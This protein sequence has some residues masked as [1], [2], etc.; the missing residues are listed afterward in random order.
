MIRQSSSLWWAPRHAY[1]HVVA[2]VFL[3]ALTPLLPAGL[4]ALAASVWLV[5]ATTHRLVARGLPDDALARWALTLLCSFLHIAAT[6]ELL[7]LF[8]V[9]N[10]PSWW[11]IVQAV[12]FALTRLVPP[13]PIQDSI[14]AEWSR[15]T[16]RLPPLARAVCTVFVVLAAVNL[17]IAALAGITEYDSI[18]T[19]VP[20][21]IDFVQQGHLNYPLHPRPGDTDAW[22]APVSFLFNWHKVYLYT[23]VISDSIVFLNIL[24]WL[25]TAGAFIATLGICHHL[26]VPR[27]IGL[28]STIIVFAAPQF[29]AQSANTMYDQVQAFTMACVVLAF[30][31]CLEKPSRSWAALFALA[32]V[33]V[34]AMKLS[35]AFMA[36]VLLVLDMVLAGWLLW[37]RQ[38]AAL[39]AG[40]VVG[41]LGLAVLVVPHFARNY[42]YYGRWMPS[43]RSVSSVVRKKSSRSVSRVMLLRTMKCLLPFSLY[44]VMPHPPSWLPFED[45]FHSKLQ[46]RKALWSHIS[47]PYTEAAAYFGIQPLALT[48]LMIVMTLSRRAW[49]S[50][51]RWLL[52][53]WLCCAVWLTFHAAYAFLFGYSPW[54]GRYLLICW[55]LAGPALAAAL[56]CLRPRPRRILI[57]IL[58]VWTSVEAT[59]FFVNREHMPFRDV[60]NI[61]RLDHFHRDPRYPRSNIPRARAFL[62]VRKAYDVKTDVPGFFRLLYFDAFRQRT[63]R[64]VPTIDFNGRD[65]VITNLHEEEARQPGLNVCYETFRVQGDV[66]LDGPRTVLVPRGNVA[67][68]PPGF[69]ELRDAD[70]ALRVQGVGAT[71]ATESAIET[72]GAQAYGWLGPGPAGSL[73]IDIEAPKAMAVWIGVHVRKFGPALATPEPPLSVY[74][75]TDLVDQIVLDRA[76]G[77]LVFVPLK[78]GPNAVR[79]VLNAWDT[80]ERYH[81]DSRPTAVLI[82]G[83]TV[84]PM[85]GPMPTAFKRRPVAPDVGEALIDITSTALKEVTLLHANWPARWG[86]IERTADGR[87]SLWM[88]PATNGDLTLM[89]H[90]REATPCVLRFDV[91]QLGV[92]LPDNARCPL[93]VVVAGQVEIHTTLAGCGRYFFPVNLPAGLTSVALSVAAMSDAER[94]GA[95]PR[96]TMLYVQQ[97]RLDGAEALALDNAL[98]LN[99]HPRVMFVPK[100][101]ADAQFVV[102]SHGVVLVDDQLN[103]SVEVESLVMRPLMIET[104]SRVAEAPLW[105]GPWSAGDMTVNLLVAE[106]Q[107]LVVEVDIRQLG[108]ALPTDDFAIIEWL[109]DGVPAGQIESVQP[110]R[111]RIPVRLEAGRRALTLR[112]PLDPDRQ[113]YGADL[114]PTMVLLGSV[115]LKEASSK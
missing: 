12:G 70:H 29:I 15:L 19:Y 43:N 88:G 46:F 52:L 115:L 98:M 27:Y 62:D 101:E 26:R 58:V 89:I 18:T 17:M 100:S 48:G 75:G 8:R 102:D 34:M 57:G 80:G 39:G 108:C 111:L 81:G 93:D 104:T 23:I 60:R 11:L 44:Y 3:A 76:G 10:E 40:V 45:D 74:C 65:A 79:L 99:R 56:I 37:K 13:T 32:H 72:S 82:D 114:R 85:T 96:P 49:R 24:G 103:K 90:A 14:S 71:R 67:P 94:Y 106:S 31:K 110:G 68:P 84:S 92:S 83:V 9:M 63:I 53:M 59:L 28:L 61:S 41:L 6:A 25:A 78:R 107:R 66:H 112:V 16:C 87:P 69:V 64:Y 38:S 86:R 77:H 30:L 5:T 47:T 54:N 113:R 2:Q 73:R 7:S 4:L 50:R 20:Y 33:G 51:R 42:D 105:L 36:P 35:W 97:V 55:F 21:V 22:V 109:V 91:A 95:D 1:R